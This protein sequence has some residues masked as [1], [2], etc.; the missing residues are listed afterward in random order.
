[1][2]EVS[3]FSGDFEK[4][5]AALQGDEAKA[6]EMEHALRHEIHVKLEENPAFYR[7]LRERLEKIIEDKKAQRITAAQQLRLF[8][9]LAK[10]AASPA[11]IAAEAGLSERAFAIYGLLAGDG[12]SA[13]AEAEVDYNEMD[14]SRKA[15]AEIIEE[16]VAED[17]RFIDWVT[18]GDLQR[19]MRNR[20]RRQLVASGQEKDEAQKTAE[21]VLEFL[22]AVAGR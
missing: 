21:R 7:S 12:E 2:K 20:I 15:T 11:A 22:K 1:M 3:I 13:V 10:D 5:M 16:L 18:K 17:V 14:L 19:E 9:E 8:N 6:S 4:K